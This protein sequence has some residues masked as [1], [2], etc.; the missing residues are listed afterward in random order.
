M[1]KAQKR[2]KQKHTAALLNPELAQELE[3]ILDRLRVQ[4]PNGASLESYLQSLRSTLAAKEV[5]VVALMERIDRRFGEVG[6][7]VLQTLHDLFSSKAF[8]TAYR[9]AAY[10][11]E[12]AGFGDR[13]VAEGVPA[14]VLV[15]GEV[16]KPIAHVSPL[17][18]DGHWFLTALLPDDQQVRTMIFAL[19]GFPFQC[20]DLRVIASSLGDYRRL[21]NQLA[22]NFTLPYQ[23][24][25]PRHAAQ[26]I[27]ELMDKGLAGTG[28]QHEKAARRLVA[29]LYEPGQSLLG[30]EFKAEAAGADQ[31]PSDQDARALVTD[32]P[33]AGLTFPKEELQPYWDRIRQVDESILVVANSVKEDRVRAI[34]AEAADWI[35]AGAMRN[36]LKRFF[37]EQAGYFHRAGKTQSALSLWKTA[38]HLQS[39]QP[40][41]RSPVIMEFITTSFYLHWQ[42]DFPQVD[43][44]EGEEV[45]ESTYRSDSGLILLK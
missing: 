13:A 4:S 2:Q 30:E 38:A 21:Q 32:L 28:Y 37:E 31:P 12:Q 41:S 36:D 10:R 6:Y 40:A 29:P 23:E 15:P 19:V 22:R 1:S 9:Q 11:M 35:C 16:K 26:V 25:P 7:R 27:L 43:Q 33:M 5:L 3:F 44:E 39:S 17:S 8:R 14:A 45:E 24:I 42:A 18:P 34:M 20:E